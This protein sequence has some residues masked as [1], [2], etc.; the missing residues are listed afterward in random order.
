MQ[1][2][3]DSVLVAS[4]PTSEDGPLTPP[5][6]L[7]RGGFLRV[8]GAVLAVGQPASI[9]VVVF[10]HSQEE[11]GARRLSGCPQAAAGDRRGLATTAVSVKELVLGSK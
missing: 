5:A 1:L 10:P 4:F 11:S 7:L 6:R 9:Q 8:W 3:L 2:L